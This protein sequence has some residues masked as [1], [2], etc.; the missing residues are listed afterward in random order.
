MSTNEPIT[1]THMTP[2]EQPPGK[3][4]NFGLPRTIH[5]VPLDYISGYEVRPGFYEINGATA[6]PGG[7]NF[8]VYSHGATSIELLLF[9]RAAEEPFAILPFPK[10]YRIGNVYSMIVF[11][12]N[13]EDFEYAYRVDGP[14][15]PKKGL[16]FNKNK[17]LLDPYARAVSGQSQWGD[18]SPRGQHYKA[19]VVKDDF[20]WGSIAPPLLPTEDLIIY[21]LHVRGFTKHGSSGVLHPGTFDGL[22]EKLPHLLELGVNVVELMPIFEFDEMQDYR[23]VDGEKLYNYWG[24][25]TVSFFSP[26]TS[27]S[28]YREHNREGNELKHLIQ[29]FNQHGIEVY[30]DVVFNHTAEGNEHGPFF[31][32]KGFDNNIY[33]LLTPDGYYYNFS[34][35][36]NSLNCN[37]PIVRQMILDCLRYWVNTYRVN[38]FRFDLASILGRNEDGSPM[39]KPPLLQALAFDPILGD[40]KLIA[41]AW[42]ADGLYQVGTFPSWNRWAEWNGR[43]RD[44]MRRYLKGDEGMAMAAALR[45]VG[46]RDIYAID[47]SENASV[48]FI[49][50]HDGFTLYDLYSYNEKHNEKN[51]WNNTDGSNDNH[52][53]NCGV[54]GDTGDPDVIFLRKRMIRNAFAI[55]MCSRGIPM[56][57]AGDEFCN[58]QFGNNNS[59][60]Q[61]NITSWLDWRLLEK[62]REIF[63]FFK[64]MIRFRK[65]HRLLRTNVSNG[66]NGFPDISFHGVTPWCE[67]FAGHDRYI[68]V[69]FTGQEK[70]S[71]PQFIYIASNAYW[72]EVDVTLPELPISMCWKV[73]VDTW[74]EVQKPYDLHSDKITLRPRSLMVVVGE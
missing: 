9:H 8:T 44:D 47:R 22:L 11:K 74:D 61:D 34:G 39:N 4:T 12:L 56:F 23:E 31:S 5:L 29:V 28:S 50:C 10:H 55:L 68:G 26:N 27:Y 54:E 53:W 38:G 24:Y 14:Y 42:D 45:V 40:V 67:H 21:E 33:Y 1:S 17:Y 25:N 43:Y 48:N 41:E 36:G 59:Y 3:T 65:S 46:S 62:N 32:F 51:G 7:V 60:C 73:V 63:E 58:T 49:T 20:D 37:H 70:S 69:M 30:L 57:L 19:R 2:Q 66:V 52:S 72:E 64:Y 35:C 15:E 16:I 13:I 71:G 6:I 18:S